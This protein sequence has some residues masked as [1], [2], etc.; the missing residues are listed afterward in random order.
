MVVEI[1]YHITEYIQIYFE[2]VIHLIF[3]EHHTSTKWCISALNILKMIQGTD[4]SL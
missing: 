3:K 1:A 4:L 2:T